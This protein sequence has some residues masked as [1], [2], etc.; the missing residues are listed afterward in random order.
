MPRETERNGVQSSFK[1]TITRLRLDN[2]SEMMGHRQ[3]CQMVCF[4][5]KNTNLG[6]VWRASDWKILI[7]FTAVWNILQTFE[8][9]YDHLV[10]FVFVWHIFS[11]F[12]I[13]HQ[14]K[15]G[16][17]GRRMKEKKKEKQQS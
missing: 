15:S 16:N 6:K 3:G 13:M 5:T 1:R 11:G 9:F 14:E 8:I 10:E 2:N 17:P 4:Q 12:G 7:Y